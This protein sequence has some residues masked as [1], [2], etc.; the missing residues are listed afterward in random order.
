M[1][2]PRPASSRPPTPWWP[3]WRP[4]SGFY[5]D[6]ETA[7]PPAAPAPPGAAAVVHYLNRDLVGDGTV[8]DPARPDGLVYHTGGEQPVLLGAFFVAPRSTTAPPPPPIS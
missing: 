5:A 7:E 2:P 6:P 1:P 4:P 8:L 3:T